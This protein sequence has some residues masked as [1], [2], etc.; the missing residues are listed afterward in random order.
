MTI[1]VMMMVMILIPGVFMLWAVWLLL[2]RGN[3]DAQDQGTY[4]YILYFE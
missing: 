4:T 1:E 2:Q 3:E